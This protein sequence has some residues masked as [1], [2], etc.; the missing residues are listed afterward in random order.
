MQL[1]AISFAIASLLRFAASAPASTALATDP[2]RT[3]FEFPNDTYVENIAV[4]PNGQVLVTVLTAPRLF[5]VDPLQPGRAVLVHTFASALGVSGIA[6][7]EPDVY[8]CI[9]GNFSFSTGDVGAGSWAIWSIDLRG[10]ALRPD[11]TLSAPPRTSQIAAVPP[12]RFLNGISLLKA[13]DKTLLVGDVNGGAIFHVDIKTGDFRVAINNTYTQVAPA[14]PFPPAGVDGVHVCEDALYFT[15]IGKSIFV[16]VPISE[17]GTAAGPFTTVAHT[18]SRLDEYDDFTFDCDGNA[19]LVTGR[20][21]SV[22][23]I[24]PG[25]RREVIIAGN[26]NSTA[27]AEPTS[28]AFGRGLLDR[29]VLYV[30]TAG[31]LATPVDGDVTIGGQLVALTTRSRGSC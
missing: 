1:I 29:N 10:V 15:N 2:V 31:G 11:G 22:E 21:N 9:T 14:S 12:A 4:R 27:I 17:D 13:K 25:G 7:Y 30:T 26:L 6:E 18:L 19:F 3:V 16:K 24:S 23:I 8:A 20:G 5:L 28:A